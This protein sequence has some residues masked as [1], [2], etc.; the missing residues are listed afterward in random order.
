MHYLACAVSIAL[1][2]FLFTMSFI[3]CMEDDLKL[4]NK[5]A[6]KQKS[7]TIRYFEAALHVCS[8]A[9]RN[10]TVECTQAK[11]WENRFNYDYD[12]LNISD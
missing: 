2:Y 9:Y 11:C 1:G 3:E 12:I 5:L 4:I 10:E 7:I 8:F 6:R